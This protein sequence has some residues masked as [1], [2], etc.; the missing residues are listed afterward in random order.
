MLVF[1]LSD[2]RECSGLFFL[3]AVTFL[4]ALESRQQVD[5]TLR[6]K[7]LKAAFGSLPKGKLKPQQKRQARF[8]ETNRLVIAPFHKNLLTILM[9]KID[10][11]ILIQNSFH[12]WANINSEIPVV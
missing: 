9:E 5:Q 8:L 4:C 3:L 2:K 7:S 10:A 1:L 11:Q 6:P 12:L